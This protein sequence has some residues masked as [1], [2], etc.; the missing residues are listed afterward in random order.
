MKTNYVINV[1]I[2]EAPKSRLLTNFLHLL[3]LP[4]QGRSDWEAFLSCLSRIY[5]AGMICLIFLNR[6]YQAG[7]GSKNI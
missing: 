7:K 3:D 5:Q 6:I 4:E 2:A 1:L